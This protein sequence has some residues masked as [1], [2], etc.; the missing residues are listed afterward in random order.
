VGDLCVGLEGLRPKLDL[1]YKRCCQSPIFVESLPELMEIY[2]GSGSPRNIRDDTM[3]HSHYGGT[4]PKKGSFG[5]DGIA[6]VAA[7]SVLQPR[8]Q[9]QLV[10]DIVN[11]RYHGSVV[12]K[13]PF[14]IREARALGGSVL[15]PIAA[16]AATFKYTPRGDDL[17]PQTDRSV[18]WPVAETVPIF[19]DVFI[20]TDL[21]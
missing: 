17:K 16:S 1:S 5:H 7:V 6:H 20:F 4:G 9:G 2:T 8:V 19:F 21:C 13:M 12:V 14:T 10:L 3:K 15:H 11:S 18:Q